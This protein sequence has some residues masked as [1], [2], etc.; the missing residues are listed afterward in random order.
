MELV[1]QIDNIVKY[2]RITQ[3]HYLYLLTL[4]MCYC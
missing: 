2:Y 3:I 4:V 1:K